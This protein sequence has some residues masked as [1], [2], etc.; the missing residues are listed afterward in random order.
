[1]PEWSNGQDLRSCGLVP[2]RVRTPFPALIMK[3]NKE[4]AF[5]RLKIP[6]EL[7]RRVMIIR[8]PN[9][10]CKFAKW[11]K[12]VR[13]CSVGYCG[14]IFKIVIIVAGDDIAE[15]DYTLAH[16]LLGHRK[17][18]GRLSWA[19]E[20]S[21]AVEEGL[22]AIRALHPDFYSETVKRIKRYQKEG[23]KGLI[24]RL[25]EKIYFKN[26]NLKKLK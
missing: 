22:L 15:N 6:K 8:L 5:K 2:T 19:K 14:P 26:V 11:T 7:R 9:W 10:L 16:E 13:K 17:D 12:L 20:E 23:P 21:Y 25:I 4:E 24:R 3:Y 1:M 18:H